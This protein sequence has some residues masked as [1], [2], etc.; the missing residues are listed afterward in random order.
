MQYGKSAFYAFYEDVNGFMLCQ[1]RQTDLMESVCLEEQAFFGNYWRII[2]QFVVLL[3]CIFISVKMVIFVLYF[4][5]LAFLFSLCMIY[6]QLICAD[7]DLCRKNSTVFDNLV[8]NCLKKEN[9]GIPVLYYMGQIS[10]CR[11]VN[12]FL[13]TIRRCCVRLF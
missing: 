9:N 3:D 10:Y 11:F 6:E 2:Y 1:N 4:K 13:H 7:F 8:M 5:C 12:G